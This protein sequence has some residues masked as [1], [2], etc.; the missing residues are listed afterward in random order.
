MRI[1]VLLAAL[2]VVAAW[3]A[4]AQ[5]GEIE[6]IKS[7][8]IGKNR[9]FIVNGKPFFPI[10]SW[11]QNPKRY[12]ARSDVGFNVHCSGKADPEAAKAVGCYAVTGFDSAA[13]GSE[14]LLGWL[15]GDE[16]D[17]PRKDPDDPNA[18]R[19][20]KRSV[21]E[22]AAN[23]KRIKAADAKRP[24]FVTFTACFMTEDSR[25]DAAAKAKLYPAYVRGCD[26]V[27]FD[28]Y[29]IYGSGHAN[30]LDWVAKGVTQLR[31]LGGPRRPLYAWIETHKGS[32]WMTYE[33]QPD[34]LP[35]HTRSEVWMAIIRGATAIGYFT[36]AWRPSFT[37]FA[38]TP[39]MQAEMKRLNS[40]ITRLAPAILADEAKSKVQM[41]LAGEEAG[42]L[43]CHTKATEHDGALYIFAQNIDLGPGAEKLRQFDPID[44][45]GGKATVRVAGLKAGT[46]I[47]VVDENRALTAGDG[48]FT[49]QFAPLAE[50]I[51]RIE[52]K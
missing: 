9:Q 4:A 11:A 47:E 33:K 29:P 17:M 1:L 2:G 12:A 42:G 8:Q 6:P 13:A 30:H 19:R 3:A 37:E 31:E 22:V 28:I 18:P 39:D 51:Y 48:Q 34:V 27:G 45:R 44:P 50:H 52:M 24:V 46:K 43:N 10:M 15:H 25:Y 35:I 40:Q 7:I 32:K 16:P 21:E 41:K 36:H 5:A 23:Y 26:V 38:P 14:Y 20:P 49:D